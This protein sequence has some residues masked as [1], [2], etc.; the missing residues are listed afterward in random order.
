MERNRRRS[1]QKRADKLERTFWQAVKRITDE[2]AA[3]VAER[4]R[5]YN[6]AR[7]DV[8]ILTYG[9]F[10]GTI[11]WWTQ[12]WFKLS[13]LRAALMGNHSLDEVKEH[14]RDLIN[15]AKYAYAEACVEIELDG[16]L[17]PNM[18]RFP[19]IEEL[20][21]DIL[22]PGCQKKVSANRRLQKKSSG[23]GP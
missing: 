12:C 13:R 23:S 2:A 1:I 21:Y 5:R 4:G 18:A 10:E 9:A 3:L 7:S 14:A 6:E 20:Q 8:S 19:K 17:G 22:D 15:Y 16:S 11:A